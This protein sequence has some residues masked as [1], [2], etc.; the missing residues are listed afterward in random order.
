MGH[1]LKYRFMQTLR[2]YS[3]MFW[4]LVFPLILGTLFYVSFGKAGMGED[5]EAIPVAVVEEQEE[6]LQGEAFR[7]FLKE[8]E[9]DIITVREMEEEEALAAL[10]GDEITG[11][12]YINREPALTI[13]ESEINQSILKSLLDTYRENAAM[14]ENIAVNHPE[15]IPDAIEALKDW[16]ENTV[17]VS[18]GGRTMDPQVG[19]FFAL[20]AYACLSGTFLGVQ[21]SFDGQANLSPLGARRSITPTSKLR[22]ILVDMITLVAIH[23]CDVLILTAFVQFVLDID[24]GGSIGAILLVDFMGS[25]IGISLGILVGCIARIS[26]DVKMGLSVLVSLFP[27]FLAGIMFPNMKDIVERYCPV[28]NRINP[29]AVLSDAFYCMGVYN[30]SRRFAMN[31]AILAVMSTLLIFGAFWA[32]RRERYDSI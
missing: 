15:K 6:S 16:R 1:L 12:F 24:L 20:I 22:L 4:A 19:Y 14:F 18:L 25:T 13:S 2:K 27:A 31:L 3:L 30:D 23:F 8:L 32:V 7:K 28:V 11:I 29:A 9:G 26:I 5:M 17:E 10:A 21:S